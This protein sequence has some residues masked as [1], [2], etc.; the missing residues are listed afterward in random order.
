LVLPLVSI[1]ALLLLPALAGVAVCAGSG[2]RRG[3]ARAGNLAYL[4]KRGKVG[5]SGSG[6]GARWSV[7]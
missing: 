5:K 7:P 2:A 6:N 4:E 3:R 1:K